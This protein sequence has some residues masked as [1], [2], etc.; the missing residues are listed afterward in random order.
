MPVSRLLWDNHR[1]PVGTNFP[2]CP[3]RMWIL[4]NWGGKP[5]AERKNLFWHCRN[6]WEQPAG[7]GFDHQYSQTLWN[8]HW[9]KKI[10]V[11][12]ATLPC[13]AQEGPSAL[14]SASLLRQTPRRLISKNPPSAWQ[15]CLNA[16]VFS[17]FP[18]IFPQNNG[19]LL[20]PKKAAALFI[21]LYPNHTL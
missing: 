17:L 4:K 11:S 19:S 21:L 3:A 20:F 2:S 14:V 15:T 1:L 18:F 10:T 12:P 16:I 5:A 13:A 7:P 8:T 9:S 6:V